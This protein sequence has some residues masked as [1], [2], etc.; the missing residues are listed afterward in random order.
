[1][2]WS[3]VAGKFLD[4]LK[5]PTGLTLIALALVFA[6]LIYVV[7]IAAMAW[8]HYVTTQDS[9]HQIVGSIQ[10]LKQTIQSYQRLAEK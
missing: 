7:P 5:K 2:S 6:F 10:D 1:M 9:T 4:L 8:V 3:D